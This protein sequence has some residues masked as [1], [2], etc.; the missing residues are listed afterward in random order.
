MLDTGEHGIR[1]CILKI[2]RKEIIMIIAGVL[3]LLVASGAI[4][5][6]EVKNFNHNIR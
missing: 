1:Y 3:L 2:R 4:I 5:W 6:R